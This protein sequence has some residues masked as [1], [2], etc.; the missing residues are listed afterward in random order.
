MREDAGEVGAEL[1]V[2][3]DEEPDAAAA[4]TEAVVCGVVWDW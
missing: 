2:G 4:V 1:G 3:E